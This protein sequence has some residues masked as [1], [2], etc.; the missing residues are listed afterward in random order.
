MYDQPR[1]NDLLAIA[2][3]T[4][5]DEV[6]PALPEDK[7][8]AGLMVANAMAIAAREAELG[9]EAWRVE[10]RLLCGYFQEAEEPGLEQAALASR[11]RELNARLAGEIRAETVSLEEG[12]LRQVLDEITRMKLRVSNPRALKAEGQE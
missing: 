8:Y 9:P 12:R 6:L 2:R 1:G 4:L 10:Y 7:R 5:I 3:E 11:V